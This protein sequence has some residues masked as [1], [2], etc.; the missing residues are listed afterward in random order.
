[1]KISILVYTQNFCGDHSTDACIALDAKENETVEQLIERA[2]LGKNNYAGKSE[3]IAIRQS[4][5]EA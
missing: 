1:M 2:K 4:H 3:Y 5:E